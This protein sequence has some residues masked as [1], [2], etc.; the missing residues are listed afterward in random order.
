MI[1]NMDKDL[2]NPYLFGYHATDGSSSTFPLKGFSIHEEGLHLIQG[3]ILRF[4]NREIKD[5]NS[6]EC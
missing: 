5:Y 3:F 2:R 6:E 4:G 1:Q